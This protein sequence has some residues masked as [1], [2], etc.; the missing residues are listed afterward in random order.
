ME[1]VDHEGSGTLFFG[2]VDNTAYCQL[3]RPY[4]AGRMVVWKPSSRIQG[5][6]GLLRELQAALKSYQ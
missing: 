2:H 5:A 3:E 6:S 4:G 1:G